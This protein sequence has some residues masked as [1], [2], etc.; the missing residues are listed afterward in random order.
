MRIAASASLLLLLIGLT[1]PGQSGRKGTVSPTPAAPPVTEDPSSF[2]ESKPRASRQYQDRFPGMSSPR[3]APQPAMTPAILA[4]AIGAKEDTDDVVKVETN[5]I[6]IPVSVYDRNGLYI[7]GLRQQEFK[8][9]EDGVEQDIAYFGTQDKPFTV[10]LLLDT[11]PSTQYKIDEIHRA[12]EA[13]VDHL[14]PQDSVMVIEFNSSVKVQ[15]QPTK[16]REKI[17]KAIYKAKFGDGTSLYNAVD[18]ALRKQLSKIEGR[19]AVVLFTDG[20]DTTSRKNTYDGTLAYAEESDSLVFP[21][22][23]NTLYD[24]RPTR[25]SS[26]SWPDIFGPPLIIRGET[27]EEYAVGRKYLE[28]LAGATGGRVFRPEATPGGLTA[29]FEGIAEELRRQY[30]IGYV[31][32]SEGTVGQRKQI[33]VRVN[34]PNLIVRSRDSYVVGAAV[35]TPAPTPAPK[36]K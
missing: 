33:K 24:T 26:S 17:R 16:D 3:N 27:P 5:L 25:S 4:P 2:S 35:S 18:E 36:S 8:I 20:V 19:K 11:S 32:R 28:E 12:A 34:R 7:P 1:C 21:I 14:S 30:N 9:F 22:Y 10:A 15:T 13:F 29:A 6:T 31:P 23:Y